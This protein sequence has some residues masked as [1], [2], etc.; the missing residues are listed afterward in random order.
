[1]PGQNTVVKSSELK[2]KKLIY[3]SLLLP[4]DNAQ[5]QCPFSF[6]VSNIKS[7]IQKQ[8]NKISSTYLN[9]KWLIF[10]TMPMKFKS[11]KRKKRSNWPTYSTS[12]TTILLPSSE[13]GK[14]IQE[15]LSNIM[16]DVCILIMPIGQQC[17][18]DGL[19]YTPWHLEV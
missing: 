2:F 7:L 1:M 6:V 19:V 5:M 9:P 12:S 11:K 4:D 14:T 15:N 10:F 16:G 8:W 17:C 18:Y 3:Y 13:S